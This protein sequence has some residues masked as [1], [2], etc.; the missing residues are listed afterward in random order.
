MYAYCVLAV[1]TALFMGQGLGAQMIRDFTGHVGRPGMG[2]AAGVLMSAARPDPVMG[3]AGPQPVV[4][5]GETVVTGAWS[6][7]H[8][9]RSRDGGT[10]GDTTVWSPQEATP[11]SS[12]RSPSTHSP[13]TQGSGTHGTA[14]VRGHAVTGKARHARTDHG[15]RDADKPAGHGKGKAHGKRHGKRRR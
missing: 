5:R 11:G 7:G 4:D 8:P 3:T 10:G 13:S 1:I 2:V 9:A 12:T 15:A 14:P 6:A